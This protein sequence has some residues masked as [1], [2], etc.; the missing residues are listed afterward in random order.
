MWHTIFFD[1][2]IILH[3]FNRYGLPFVSPNNILVSTINGTGALIES[4]YVITFLIY[5]P[6]KVRTKMLGLLM[7]VLTV[8]STVALVSLFALHGNTRKLLCGFAASIFSILMYASP[9]SIMVR[10]KRFLKSHN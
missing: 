4:I 9:L 5:A 1:H 6:K 8:F 10:M 3:L 7:L 2:R